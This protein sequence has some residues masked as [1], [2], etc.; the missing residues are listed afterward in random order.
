MARPLRLDAQI[1]T[2]ASASTKIQLAILATAMIDALGGPPEFHERFTFPLITGM[3]P[4]N[5]F[6]LPPGVWT[7]DTSMTLCLAQSLSL[8]TRSGNDGTRGNF[9]EREQLEAY[10][11]WYRKGKLSAIGRCFDIGTTIRRALHIYEQCSPDDEIGIVLER[12]AAQLGGESSSGNGS[13]MRVLPIGLAYWRDEG[14]A[15]EHARRSSRT[16]H[17]N[18]LCQE[19]CEV[20]TAAIVR[21]M[22]ASTMGSREN[23]TKL[24]LVKFFA[25]FAY[26]DSKLQKALSLPSSAPPV[27]TTGEQEEYYRKHH[28]ILLLITKTSEHYS[29]REGF[30]KPIPRTEELPSTGYVLHTLVAAL[31]CFLATETFEEGAI[32]AVNLGSDADTVGAVYAGLAGCWYGGKEK[33]GVDDLF[34]TNR[35]RGWRAGLVQHQL[36][37]EVANG[38]VVFSTKLGE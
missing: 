24:D 4:N 25:E 33:A 17:P 15:K 30:S 36:V 20:W 3:Q 28:P 18:A 34:W 9:D 6:N 31:Y 2:P 14:L 27:P 26:T 8:A 11:A 21:V 10:K 32:M 19:A 35:T 12:I 1:P 38:L 37:E 22:Q 5:N 29:N 23:Y 16:T 7:D 13:L